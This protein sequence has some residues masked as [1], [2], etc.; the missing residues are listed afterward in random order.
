MFEHFDIIVMGLIAAVLVFK[1]RGVL[2]RRTG[3]ERPRANP[4]AETR[5]QS[6]EASDDNVVTLPHRVETDPQL[7]EE[8]PEGSLNA[9][10]AQIRTVDPSFNPHEFVDGAR[11]AFRMIIEAFANGDTATL[12][13]LLGDE[14]YDGFSSAIRD[15]MAEN[16]HLETS[17]R[18]MKDVDL[19]DAKLEGRTAIVTLKFVT[20]QVSVTRDEDGDVV[21]GDPDEVIEVTDIWTFARNTRSTDPNWTLIETDTPN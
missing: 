19:I 6:E 2:G 18:E 21:D 12:R 3:H 10:L 14:L 13:P 16:K 5:R 7:D 9:S 11:V 8:G 20:D 1:L 17:I 4:Y 15:R